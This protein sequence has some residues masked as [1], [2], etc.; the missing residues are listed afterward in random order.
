MTFKISNI[1]FPAFLIFLFIGSASHS[2]IKKEY[3]RETVEFM[4]GLNSRIT[5]YPGAEKA[6]DFTEDKLKEFKIG[7]VN[8]ESFELAVPVDRGGHLTLDGLIDSFQLHGLWPNLVRTT[9]VPDSGVFGE[10]VYGRSGSYSDLS[11]QKIQDNFVLL[12]FNS[13]NNW[14]ISASLGA[15]AII[16]IEPEEAGRAQANHKFSSAP[17]DVPRFWLEREQGILLRDLLL[18]T[19]YRSKITSRMDWELGQGH[20]IHVI[21]PGIDPVLSKET[22]I[23]EAYFDGISIVPG[24]APSA[25]TSSSIALLLEYARY[26]KYKKPRRTVVLAATDAHFSGMQGISHFLEQHA[27]THP[28]YAKKLTKPIEPSLFI[29]LDIST[30][31]DQL[32]IWNNTYSYDLKRFF[33]PFGR[34]FSDYNVQVGSLL[35]RNSDRSLVNGISPI[36]GM[37]WE[38]FMPGG[39]SVNSIKALNAGIVSLAL[40]TVNDGRYK[41]NTPHDN[42]EN[43]NFKNLE[44]QSDLINNLLGLAINDEDLFAELEDFTPVLKD[45]LRGLRTK[46]RAF[47]RRS[48]VPDRGVDDALV[49]IR[50]GYKPHKGVHLAQYHFTNKEG[51]VDIPGLEIGATPMTAYVVE[52]ES[53][54]II[55]APDLSERATKFHGAP[56]EG[57]MLD[58]KVRWETN[59]KTIVVFPTIPMP[60]YSMIDPQS[61]GAFGGITVIDKNGVTPR[62]FGLA[63][64][65]RESE[66][67]GVLFTPLD[68]EM[69]EGYKLMVGGRMLLLNSQGSHNEEIAR[70]KGYNPRRD[71]LSLTGSYIARDMWN[72]NEARLNTMRKHAIENQRLTRLH[73]SGKKYIEAALESKNAADWEQYASNIRAGLGVISRAYPEVLTTLNDVIKGIVFFLALLIPAAFLGERLIFASP[74]IRR[75]LMGFFGILLLAWVLISQVHP[76]FEIAHPLVVLLAF[77]IM[78]MAILV[79]IMIISRFNRFMREYQAK[80]ANVYETDISRASASNAAFMLGISNMRRRKLRTGLTLLTLIILTFTVLSFTS[81]KSDISYLAFD[82]SHKGS[83]EGTLIRDRNWDILKM[84]T[85]DFAQSHFGETGTVVPRNWYIAV[86]QEEKKYIEI[87]HKNNFVRSTGL[88]GFQ[89]N[90]TSVTNLQETLS[91]GVFLTSE[92]SNGCLISEEMAHSLDINIDDPKRS[93]IMIFGRFF[94]VVGIFS[95]DKFDQIKDLDGETLTPADFQMSGPRMPGESTVDRMSL[96]LSDATSEI[97]PFVHLDSDNVVILNY[98]TLREMG[99]TLRSIAVAIPYD[100]K[101]RPLIE[102]FLL[103]LQITLFAGFS[104]QTGIIDVVSYTSLPTGSM[105]G[106]GELII[107]MIIAGLIVLNAM[108]GAVYE[109][110]REINIYSSVGLAPLHIALLFV[111]EAVV[112]SII[113]VTVG[114]ILGQGIGKIL[115]SYNLLAGMN[116]NYSSVAAIVSAILVMAVVLLSTIYPARLAAQSAVPD[117]VRRWIPPA[118][119]GNKWQFEFPFMVGEGEVIGLCGFLANYFK[120]YSEESIGDFYAEKVRIVEDHSGQK[121]EY[122]VQLLLWLTP[123]DMGVSEFLQLEFL[124]GK[125]S[126]VYNVEVFIERLSGQDTNWIRV[127]QKF[128]NGLRKEFLLWHTLNNSM[129][130]FHKKSAY[131]MLVESS[132]ESQTA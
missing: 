73:N 72:L 83:Y 97:K 21:V 66:P 71:D 118:P 79:L 128:I 76:A 65:R 5:G 12:D 77:A 84:P 132:T 43:V 119:N 87:K 59:E 44:K 64:G 1:F 20:N 67:I 108:L 99:G 57:W 25:E 38:T 50:P 105:D 3:L 95:A 124:P 90:E 113:G 117:T 60:F 48:Q 102:E 18:E 81:F 34:R 61:M 96:Q 16:F 100:V 15:R 114:Y 33:V 9:T 130:D 107:P 58:A 7:A 122:A 91:S 37:D 49:V 29:S 31:T 103:R 32:G 104:N 86:D 4:A 131:E 127:N 110:F 115:I 35:G 126:G 82:M 39:I 14:L 116:L 24:L 123:F 30:Q 52:N 45:N 40:V 75:Q 70:G 101:I 22:V 111:A 121:K 54:K 46:I 47:P 23:I 89:P 80:T 106:L 2:Q 69:E 10:I 26:L 56:F 11:G 85:L 68:S 112:Y 92:I 17:L 36:R 109:R 120:A 53:G 62:Q 41:I 125:V 28:Y 19:S 8:R 129:R 55:Y 63:R 78:A 74:D 6:A 42:L 13:W 51:V 94:K 98:D 93:R 27:R 88:L